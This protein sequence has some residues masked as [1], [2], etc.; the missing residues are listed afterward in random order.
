VANFVNP[1][2]QAPLRSA[3]QQCEGLYRQS[4]GRRVAKLD[5]LYS[6]VLDS[7]FPIRAQGSIASAAPDGKE[8]CAVMLDGACGFDCWRTQGQQ[9][10]GVK[11]RAVV[12]A[13][14]ADE[15]LKF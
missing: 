15:V 4:N 7:M 14:E 1:I 10:M 8:I 6:R 5:R 9:G 2:R 12:N 11:T 3:S 13:D